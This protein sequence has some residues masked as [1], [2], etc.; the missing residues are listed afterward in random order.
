[1]SKNDPYKRSDLKRAYRRLR[2]SYRKLPKKHARYAQAKEEL[3]ELLAWCRNTRLIQI[4]DDLVQ[5]KMSI[6]TLDVKR[7]KPWDEPSEAKLPT[8]KV[9]TTSSAANE[10]QMSGN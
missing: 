4:Q 2:K 6:E 10:H 7:K 1:M 8:D 9:T 5:L 3:L